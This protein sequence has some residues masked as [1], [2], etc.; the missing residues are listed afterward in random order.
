MDLAI[1]VAVGSS[2][3]VA[4][5][6]LPLVVVIG[7]IAGKND[8]DLDFNSFEIIIL[9]ISVLL[10]NYLIG[11]GKSHWLEGVLLCVLYLIIAL[12]AWFFPNAASTTRG[13]AS[14]GG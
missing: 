13:T 5:L 11:D 10:V 7:W 14:S 1:G 12:A 8:M 4:L 3:Q 2:M 9:F 6:V